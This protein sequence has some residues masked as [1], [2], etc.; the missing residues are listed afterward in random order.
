MLIKAQKELEDANENFVVTHNNHGKVHKIPQ[1]ESFFTKGIVL[2]LRVEVEL[3]DPKLISLPD[4][5][6]Y[7]MNISVR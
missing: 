2:S 3:A 1:F 5:L 7:S 6:F 4:T